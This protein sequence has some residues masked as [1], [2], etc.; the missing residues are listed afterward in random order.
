MIQIVEVMG[1]STQGMTRPFIFS[2]P[3]SSVGMPCGRSASDL[4]TG[5]R[6]PALAP[7]QERGS[8]KQAEPTLLS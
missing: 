6:A 3:R 7:T 4:R 8:Q 1:R 2:F 5:R